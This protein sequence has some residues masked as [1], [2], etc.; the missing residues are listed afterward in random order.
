MRLRKIM[1]LLCTVPS[2]ISCLIHNKFQS[3]RCPTRPYVTW[4]LATP[5]LIFNLFPWSYFCPSITGLTS[6]LF[7]EHSKYP[8]SE[9]LHVLFPFFL[10][11]FPQ[12]ICMAFSLTSFWSHKAHIMKSSEYTLFTMRW[13]RSQKRKGR[14]LSLQFLLPDSSL[15]KEQQSIRTV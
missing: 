3:P 7:L 15:S 2:N 14:S 12:D 8:T 5:D 11:H 1:S 6:S 9:S 4:S 10:E 13:S